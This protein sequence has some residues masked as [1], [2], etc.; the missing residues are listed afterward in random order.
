MRGFARGGEIVH[1]GM[2]RVLAWV[3]V[4]LFP[5][6]VLLADTT[7]ALVSATGEATVNGMPIQQSTAVFPGDRVQTGKQGM[8]M[9]SAVGTSVMMPPSTM[10][11]LAANEVDVACG[12]AMVSTSR[13]MSARVANL[14]VSPAG[15]SAKFEVRQG[16]AEA[17]VTSREGALAIS[18]GRRL[19]P[20]GMLLASMPGCSAGSG[21][22]RRAPPPAGG[23]NKSVLWLPLG[24]AALAA[25]LVWLTT[26]GGPHEISPTIPRPA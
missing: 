16:D 18:D 3:M 17:Q 19:Q 2:I 13:G 11:V 12:T 14:T 5:S 21:Q 9:L 10:V 23:Q 8:A 7:S 24:V 25:L 20:G 1:N 6:S 26:R 22:A 4:V 15:E